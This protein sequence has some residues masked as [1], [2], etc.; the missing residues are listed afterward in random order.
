MKEPV[1]VIKF[2][3]FYYILH[4]EFLLMPKDVFDVHFEILTYSFLEDLFRVLF[5]I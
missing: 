2:V 4:D 5:I 3:R 1:G